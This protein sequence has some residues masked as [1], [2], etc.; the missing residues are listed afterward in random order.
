MSTGGSV[1]EVVG[2]ATAVPSVA[3]V[4]S[5]EGGV[6]DSPAAA[7]AVSPLP[8]AADDRV[9]VPPASCQPPPAPLPSSS[10]GGSGNPD[11]LIRKIADRQLAASWSA[12]VPGGSVRGAGEQPAIPLVS[13]LW[14]CVALRFA[15]NVK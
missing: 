3:V 10:V 11:E 2:A 13:W 12:A 14:Y 5:L 1:E 7:P 4:A 15:L 8:S 9:G 6:R